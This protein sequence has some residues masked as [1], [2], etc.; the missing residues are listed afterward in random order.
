MNLDTITDAFKNWLDSVLHINWLS[1]LITIIL[2]CVITAVVAHI[3]TL[4]LKKIFTSTR[5]PLP[6]ASIFINIGRI[7]TWII[8]I[9]VILSSCFNVNI[10][11]AVTALGI[12]G[13]AISL[14]FQDTLSNLIGGLQIL[15]TGLVEPGDRISVGGHQGVVHDV[16]WRHTTII[17]VRDERVVIP[18]SVI[19]SEAL[20]KLAPETDIHIEII[21]MPDETKNLSEQITLM[22]NEVNE[23]VSKIA[24]INEPPKITAIGTAERGYRA[25]L[26]FEIGTGTK[27]S[28]VIDTAMKAISASA[29]KAK[30]NN[31]KPTYYEGIERRARIRKEKAKARAEAK[32]KAKAEAKTKAKAETKAKAKAKLEPKPK[33]DVVKPR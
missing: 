11:A 28:D 16:T 1:T 4:G 21:I 9:C 15:M 23:A 7:V 20:I 14:G 26:T 17:T 5:G 31:R 32:T 33:T 19:N 10:G 24:V 30:T 12:G 13:I 22:E 6:S 3:V 25:M 29:Y 2:I 18:N 27:R 8:G